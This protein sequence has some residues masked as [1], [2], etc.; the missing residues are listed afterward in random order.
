MGEIYNGG[1]VSRCGLVS[2][3]FNLRGGAQ[4]TGGRRHCRRSA[5][6]GHP[7]K[8]LQPDRLFQCHYRLGLQ[9]GAD[10]RAVWPKCFREQGDRAL[11]LC[12]QRF[13]GQPTSP[14]GGVFGRPRLFT[15]LYYEKRP[16]NQNDQ[17]AL[18]GSPPWPRAVWPAAPAFWHSSTPLYSNPIWYSDRRDLNDGYPLPA[19]QNDPSWNEIGM[20]AD[21]AGRRPQGSGTAASPYQIGLPPSFLPGSPIR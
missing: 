4:L 16:Q 10:R 21:L 18:P 8:L 1:T 5:H 3:R 9:R 6:L 7:G 17:A 15:A 14:I 12:G 19:Y 11:L 2:G 20:Q 13:T